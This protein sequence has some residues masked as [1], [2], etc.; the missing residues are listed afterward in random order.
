MSLSLARCVE[1]VAR[2]LDSC[3]PLEPVRLCMSDRDVQAEVCAS[4]PAASASMA[5]LSAATGGE[6]AGRAVDR[7]DGVITADLEDEVVLVAAVDTPVRGTA[8]RLRSTST[9]AAAALLRTLAPWTAALDQELLSGAQL[10]VDDD[11]QVFTV[12]LL[13]TAACGD[14]VESVAAAAGAGLEQ[15]RTWRTDSGLDGRGILP[16]G[17]TVH[18]GIVRLS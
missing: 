6:V 16:C 7:D 1:A 12:R 4:G 5:R 15:V 9:S 11:G 14:D 2:L 13:A 8:P 3:G 18:I 10:W 17:R